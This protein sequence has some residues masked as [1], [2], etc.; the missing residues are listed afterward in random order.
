MKTVTPECHSQKQK[1]TDDK[2]DPISACELKVDELRSEACARYPQV[3]VQ[4]LKLRAL[5][6]LIWVLGQVYDTGLFVALHKDVAKQAKMQPQLVDEN[7]VVCPVPV[8][9]G[10]TT[11]GC[12]IGRPADSKP[13][14]LVV[15]ATMEGEHGG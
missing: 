10:F 13:T 4:V 11:E 15:L 8:A 7:S 2:C 1:W 3:A 6:E 9:C 14:N 12:V 5:A